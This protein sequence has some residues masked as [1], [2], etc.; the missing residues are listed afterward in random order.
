MNSFDFS[1]LTIL[2]ASFFGSFHCIAMCGG[3]VAYNT[4]NSKY[5]IFA[6]IIYNFGR[7]T[8]YS[9]LGFFAGLLGFTLNKTLLFTGV[10]YLATLIIGVAL[11]IFGIKH[12]YYNSFPDQTKLFHSS[13]FPKFIKTFY[14]KLLKNEYNIGANNKAFILGLCST[15]LPCGWLYSFVSIAATSGDPLIGTFIM[16]TFWI[17]TLPSLLLVALFTKVTLNS[18]RK[19]LPRLTALLIIISGFISISN[20]YRLHNSKLS[21][22]LINENV[23]NSAIFKALCINY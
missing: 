6:N 16:L 7:L 21:T 8:T 18:F 12:F 4:G 17:G 9:L 19:Y 10:S 15:L 13:I 23:K 14:K 5:K 11:I 1:L 2:T 22:N 20:H 3:F